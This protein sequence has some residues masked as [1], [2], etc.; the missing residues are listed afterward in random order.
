M[1]TGLDSEGPGTADVRTP[2]LGV[3]DPIPTV[4]ADGEG[5][6][7]VESPSDIVAV[8]DWPAEERSPR[9]TPRSYEAVTWF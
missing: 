7:R 3:E 8:I 9:L 5:T 6:N 4:A 1:L 2:E